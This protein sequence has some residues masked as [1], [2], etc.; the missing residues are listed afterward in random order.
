MSDQTQPL[1]EIRDLCKH[2]PLDHKNTLKAVNHVS[3][4]IYKLSLIHILLAVALAVVMALT[5]LVACAPSSA[6][7]GGEAKKVL[8]FA[9][10]TEP[11]CLLYTSTCWCTE[12][13]CR[14][15]TAGERLDLP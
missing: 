12:T 2:F 13:L 15:E 4:T 14:C 10:T 5:A 7:E 1:F 11:T 8:R 6:S 3:L 9:T